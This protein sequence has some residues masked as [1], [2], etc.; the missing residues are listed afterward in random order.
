MRKSQD[1]ARSMKLNPG[2]AVR[3]DKGNYHRKNCMH[4]ACSAC[5][6]QPHWRCAGC[7][8]FGVVRLGRC[9]PCASALEGRR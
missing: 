4:V 5:G 8:R 9:E 1:T 2:Q 6:L 7:Q 3:D